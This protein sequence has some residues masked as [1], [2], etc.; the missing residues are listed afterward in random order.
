MSISPLKRARQDCENDLSPE[1]KSHVDRV[2]QLASVIFENLCPIV[3]DALMKQVESRVS[4]RL[5]RDDTL[6]DASRKL[7]IEQKVE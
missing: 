1:K 7:L 6:L 3:D 4:F 2:M 5:S